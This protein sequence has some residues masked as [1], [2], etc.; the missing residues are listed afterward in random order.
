MKI[1]E[2][3]GKKVRKFPKIRENRVKIGVFL[4]ILRGAKTTK[5]GKYPPDP[6]EFRWAFVAPRT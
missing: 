3:F 4:T 2:N 1:I 6:P 5:M